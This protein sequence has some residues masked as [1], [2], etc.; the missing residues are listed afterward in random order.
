MMRHLI[1]AAAA[2]V[3]AV[4]GL[5]WAQIADPT[6]SQD[7]RIPADAEGDLHGFAGQA[8]WQ[9]LATCAG[10]YEAEARR[11]EASG[12]VSAAQ[13]MRDD[14]AAYFRE[15][16]HAVLTMNRGGLEE[17]TYPIL[18]AE[19]EAQTAAAEADLHSF[20]ENQTRCEAASAGVADAAMAE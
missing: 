17:E 11:L 19:I 13:D 14:Y 8:W 12:H 5:G 18:V 1:M 4:P 20:S 3:L 2:A 7:L 6:T 16:A 10:A 15:P 9:A